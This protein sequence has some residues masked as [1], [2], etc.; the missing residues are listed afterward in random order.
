M[1]DKFKICQLAFTRSQQYR[2]ESFKRRLE[3]EPLL[4][5]GTL[6]DSSH[7]LPQTKNKKKYEQLVRMLSL[8]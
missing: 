3:Q 6:L 7:S 4:S 2:L 8:T 1:F 5:W